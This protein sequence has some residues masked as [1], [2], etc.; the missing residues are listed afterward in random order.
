MDKQMQKVI[1]TRDESSHWYVIPADLYDE[2]SKLYQK[3]YEDDYEAQEEFEEK[4]GQYRTGGDLNNVQ[5][6]A[7]V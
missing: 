5:L 7:E 3:A 1:A 6:W 4:F 2:F